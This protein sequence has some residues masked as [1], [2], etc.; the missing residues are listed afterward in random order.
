MMLSLD[1]FSGRHLCVSVLFLYAL[2]F[3]SVITIL[4]IPLLWVFFLWFSLS[5]FFSFHLPSFPLLV[6]LKRY[7]MHVMMMMVE[8][9]LYPFQCVTSGDT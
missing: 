4:N 9:I 2:F 3:N 7:L 1:I 6:Y 8:V 5:C